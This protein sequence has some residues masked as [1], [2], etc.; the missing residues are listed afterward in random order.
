MCFLYQVFCF[1]SFFSDL[2]KYNAFMSLGGLALIR[3]TMVASCLKRIHPLLFLC[4][5]S[6]EA[7]LK[8]NSATVQVWFR[9][10]RDLIK[11]YCWAYDIFENIAVFSLDTEVISDSFLVDYK[12]YWAHRFLQL[13]QM[14]FRES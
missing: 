13:T 4:F 12:F 9:V 11:E 8:E 2:F 6:I 14:F 1:V 10:K 7:R 3:K 5:G